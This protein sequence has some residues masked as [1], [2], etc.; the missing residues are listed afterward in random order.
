MGQQQLLLIVLGVIIVGI[1]IAVGIN[2]FQTSAVESN[3]QQIISD[4][5][6]LGSKAQRYY[7]LPATMGGG[8]S[9]YASFSLTSN[10][11]SNSNG[12]YRLYSGTKPSTT[13]T[14]PAYS[15]VSS[16]GTISTIWIVGWGT[17]Q[18]ASNNKVTKCVEVTAT[19]VQVVAF[20]SG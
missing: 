13:Q 19:S 8:G 16:S 3:T 4:L 5:V 9:N 11:Y 20:T 1:A 10:E 14:I 7:K 6:Q 15:D 12:S 2:Q 17:E 18:D